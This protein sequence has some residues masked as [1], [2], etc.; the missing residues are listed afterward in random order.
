MTDQ[1]T[2]QNSNDFSPTARWLALILVALTYFTLYLH[3]SLINYLQ[4]PMME[5]LQIGDDQVGWLQTAFLFPYALSQLFVGY[6]GDRFRRRTVLI[7]SLLASAMLLTAMGFA[8]SFLGMVLLRVGLG[9]AQAACVPAIASVMADCFTP[10]NRST[11]V[12]TY[13][14]SYSLALV[15][16]GRYGGAIADVPTWHITWGAEEIGFSGWRMAMVF[17]AGIGTLI[18]VVLFVLFREPAR[19][20]RVEQ[21]GLGVKG[22]SLFKTVSAV[23][24]V[25]AYRVL[26]IVFVMECILEN[27]VQF[28]LPR[29]FE[30]TFEMT[31]KEAGWMATVWIQAGRMVGLLVGGRLADIWANLTRG[32]RTWVQVMGALAW[33]PALVVIGMVRFEFALIVAMC[34]YGLGVGLYQANLWTTTFEVTDPAARA[35]AIGL[36]NVASGI[37]ASWSSGVVGVLRSSVGLGTQLASLS[38]VATF[39]GLLLLLNIKVFLPR[40]YRGP[41]Q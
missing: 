36:L 24:S 17:F 31:L 20:E 21:K 7:G 6:L 16:A 26:A 27:I 30:A 39:A 15:I 41:L 34:C 29:Y 8:Q 9:F 32:G 14:F 5:D 33:I 4:T 35:T 11:A 18:A 13:L 3:R 22:G 19:T 2:R 25:N 1:P 40:D 10:K 23:L 28:W 12:A 38:V 37:G